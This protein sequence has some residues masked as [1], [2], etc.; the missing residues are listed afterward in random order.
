[1]KIKIQSVGMGIAEVD[2]WRNEYLSWNDFYY[3]Q[4]ICKTVTILREF[5]TSFCVTYRYF[6]TKEEI[7]ESK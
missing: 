5:V 1:M 2:A 3:M 4:Y 7:Y 6:C